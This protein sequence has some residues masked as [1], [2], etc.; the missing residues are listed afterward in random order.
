M[1]TISLSF[2]ACFIIL[3]N[4]FAGSGTTGT[5][6]AVQVLTSPTQLQPTNEKFKGV[7]DLREETSTG[8]VKYKYTTGW[9]TSVTEAT[10]TRLKMIE[11]GF[12]DAF[13]VTYKEGTRVVKTTDATAHTTKTWNT[14]TT[15][16][17]TPTTGT[18]TPTSTTPTGT[19]V[20]TTTPEWNTTTTANTTAKNNTVTTTTT[21]KTTTTMWLTED[22]KFTST[23]PPSTTTPTGTTTTPTQN[24]NT[25]TT[26]PTTTTTT[27]TTTK[28]TTTTTWTVL[29][30]ENNTNTTPSTGT[31]AT[32]GTTPTTEWNTTTTT[33]TTTN[34]KVTKGYGVTLTQKE[35]E[36]PGGFD[37]LYVYII[38]NMPNSRQTQAHGDW[39]HAFISFTVNKNGKTEN[40]K[41]LSGINPE[42][43]N[44]AV[45]M[46]GKMPEWTPA[47]IDGNPID[48]QFVLPLDVFIPSNVEATK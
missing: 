19:T 6:Y 26:T 36:F 43:D 42:T 16:T 44:A 11:A 7:T 35:P 40:A 30:K 25:T 46:I 15:T 27:P 5:T 37:S 23:P 18:T 38:N 47:T 1:K 21:K 4:A 10:Q 33:P 17:T 39:R 45:A 29:G 20:L 12:K 48:K 14:T 28:K 2:I 32:T 31:T 3:A 41:M 9:T 13:I 24:W 34:G 8:N 22:G